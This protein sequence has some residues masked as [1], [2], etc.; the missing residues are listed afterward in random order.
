MRLNHVRM[1]WARSF[2]VLRRQAGQARG[3]SDG[4]RRF[5]GAEVGHLRNGLARRR[6]VHREPLARICSNKGAIH[7]GIVPEERFVGQLEHGNLRDGLEGESFYIVPEPTAYQN[8][9]CP[10]LGTSLAPIV[11]S[12]EKCA[13]GVPFSPFTMDG[14]GPAIQ[15]RASASGNSAGE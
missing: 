9:L 4:A 5:L 12:L 6:I 14:L 1:R 8:L 7:I 2:A 3:R 13:Q 11:R 10:Q 15:P